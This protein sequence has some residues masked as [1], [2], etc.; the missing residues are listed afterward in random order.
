MLVKSLFPSLG[1]RGRQLL[2]PKLSGRRLVRQG[3]EG[4]SPPHWSPQESWAG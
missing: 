3:R 4:L 2:G 1:E